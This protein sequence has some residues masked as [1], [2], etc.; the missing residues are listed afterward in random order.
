MDVLVVRFESLAENAEAE[1]VRVLQFLG[2]TEHG[3]IN[4]L[5]RDASRGAHAT[6]SSFRQLA[7]P[8]DPHM[9][10]RWRD[11]RQ[12]ISQFMDRLMPLAQEMGYDF[13]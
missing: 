7:D 3:A 12:Q 10:G 5:I 11:Y 1:I 13:D 6:R 4:K 9:H 8:L 2:L